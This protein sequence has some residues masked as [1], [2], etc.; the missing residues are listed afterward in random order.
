MDPCSARGRDTAA[1]ALPAALGNRGQHGLRTLA[2]CNRA[3]A[4][5]AAVRLEPVVTGA[6]LVPRRPVHLRGDQRRRAGKRPARDHGGAQVAGDAAP[7]R[8]VRAPVHRDLPDDGRAAPRAAPVVAAVHALERH[9]D[10]GRL[11]ADGG[12]ARTGAPTKH[13]RRDGF[14]RLRSTARHRYVDILS[15]HRDAF[16]GRTDRHEF[17]H[18]RPLRLDEPR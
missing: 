4:T 8:P 9:G 5:T 14:P 1:P 2:L 13:P 7:P 6:G 3:P 11:A 16:L 15:A 12:P 17:R 10:D 18:D